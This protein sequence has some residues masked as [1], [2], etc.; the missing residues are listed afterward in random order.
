MA[1]LTLKRFTL[2]TAA[3]ALGGC[4]AGQPPPGD[5]VTPTGD[6]G[7]QSPPPGSDLA[8][9]QEKP[10]PEDPQLAQREVNYGLALRS[11]SIKLRGDLPSLD[12]SRTVLAAASPK[13]A[14]ENTI[15]AWLEDPRFATQMVTFFRNTFRMGG[16]LSDGKTAL[17][18]ETAPNFAAQL[19]VEDRNFLDV[20]TATSGTCPTHDKGNFVSADCKNGVPV[21][22]GVLTDPG[23]QAHFSSSMAFRRVRWVQETFAC[24]KFPVEYSK[25]PIPMGAGQYASPWPFNSI[26]GGDKA[27]IDFHDTKSVVCANCHATMNHIAPLFARFD[28]KGMWMDEIQVTVPVNGLPKAKKSDWLPGGE[29][30]AWRFGVSVSDLPQLGKAMAKDPEIANC[31]VTRI[32]DWAMSKDDVVSDLATV[33]ESV[34]KPYRETFIAEK[35]KLKS[36]IRKAFTSDDFVK[37]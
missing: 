29:D 16:S 18:L 19:V 10:G 6:A 35:G 14:Y 1:K 30:T 32:Y 31:A 23:V 26:S 20:L 9:I 34:I 4:L 3:L 27:P 12:E 21:A 37:F 24:R 33:P 7:T 5:T 13:E 8:M 25:N 22:A 11:A 15:D 28:A 17:S 2:A 36:V